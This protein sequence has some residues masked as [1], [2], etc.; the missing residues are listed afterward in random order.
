MSENK[1]SISNASSYAEIGEFWDE[2]D[3]GEFEEQTY[4]VEFDVS[5]RK[6]SKV[7]VPLER[8]VAEFLRTAAASQGVSTETL[9]NNWLKETIEQKSFGR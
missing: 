6:T 3:L 1:S 9:L 7:Y 2:H 5:I 8:E 4:P